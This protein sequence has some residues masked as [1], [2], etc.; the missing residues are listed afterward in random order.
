MKSFFLSI[1]LLFI[2]YSSGQYYSSDDQDTGG[3][4]PTTINYCDENVNT[5][6][7]LTWDVSTLGDHI[8]DN[9]FKECYTIKSAMLT[10]VKTVGNGAFESAGDIF[11]DAIELSFPDLTTI[12]ANAFYGAIIKSLVA[13]KVQSIG[14]EAFREA[15]HPDG[16]DLTFSELTTTN[17]FAFMNANIKSLVVPELITVDQ[18]E[19]MYANIKSLVAPKLQT[20]GQ[21]TFRNAGHSDGMDLSFATLTQ[22]DAYAFTEA[23][24]KK[25]LAPK[26]TIIGDGAFYQTVISSYVF[27]PEA[28]NVFDSFVNVIFV[29]DILQ[30][31]S[32]QQL[33]DEYQSRGA[34]S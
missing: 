6:G 13:P 11:G 26:L 23:K 8:P 34:C 18:N 10:G 7:I 27:I 4:E 33:K 24:I 5:E 15:G 3:G 29:S 16:M 2:S 19:F 9:A 1:L 22:V 28:S 32:S 31:L 17:Q 20:I 21:E 12:G 25:L 14:Q 30:G